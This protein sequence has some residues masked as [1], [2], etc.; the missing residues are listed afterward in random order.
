MIFTEY[1]LFIDIKN[2]NLSNLSS[3]GRNKNGII[4]SEKELKID[5]IGV[6]NT[7]NEVYE[8]FGMPFISY[9]EEPKSEIIYLYEDEDGVKYIV[10][11]NC[12]RELYDSRLQKENVVRNNVIT[13]VSVHRKEK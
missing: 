1:Y 3:Y 10:T 8:K 5:G 6:G 12:Y 2:N 9:Y 13:S 7:R 4:M 11:F